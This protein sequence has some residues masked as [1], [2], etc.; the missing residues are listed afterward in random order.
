[1]KSKINQESIITDLRVSTFT[2]HITEFPP[3]ES[4]LLVSKKIFQLNLIGELLNYYD[5]LP[6]I[7]RL[8]NLYYSNIS[9]LKGAI[10]TP[11]IVI[12]E[13][14]IQPILKIATNFNSQLFKL[15]N[16][17]LYL[18]LKKKIHQRETLFFL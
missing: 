3:K 11:L 6:P 17:V 7:T 5:F 1:M 10:E 13:Q 16:E 12:K 8:L 14:G 2:N 15:S 9:S 4:D 18:P